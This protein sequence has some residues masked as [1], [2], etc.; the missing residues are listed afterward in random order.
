MDYEN[1]ISYIK[2]GIM[3]IMGT[4]VEVKTHKILKN[5]DI[6]LDALT[7]LEKDNSISPTIYLNYFYEEFL[8]G[9]EIGDVINEVYGL[10]E[11]HRK[12][13]NFDKDFFMDFDKLRDRIAFKLVNT[14]SNSKL[15]KDIPHIAFLDLS[16]VFYCLL[17]NDYLGT[18]TALIHNV[19]RDMWEVSTKELFELA[20]IN[21]PRLLKCE[22]KDMNDLIK[23][24]LVDDLQKTIFERDDRYDRNCINTEAE[25]VAEGLMKNITQVKDQL[26]MYVLTNNQR[27]NG[28]VCILYDEILKKFAEKVDCDVYI[29]PS[30][31][32]E[33]ILVPATEGI[34]GKEL[35]V[36]VREVNQKELDKIDVLANNIYYYSRER[37]EIMINDKIKNSN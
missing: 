24:I 18:A 3:H 8:K 36:M 4:G 25:K 5:N 27:T 23:E 1:F 20:K 19:H 29:L 15:L 33:V 11:E 32:H 6:E 35:S 16:I 12:K 10:Y 21:T 13:L 31:V 17:D 37:D 28:A 7:I 34:D 30:S 26:A 9:K 14:K 2:D 22:I